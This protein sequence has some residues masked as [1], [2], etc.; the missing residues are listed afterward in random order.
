VLVMA[1]SGS[2]KA[3]PQSRTAEHGEAT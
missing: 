1:A 3:M 2:L